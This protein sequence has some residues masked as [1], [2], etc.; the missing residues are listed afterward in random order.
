M[1]LHP[2]LLEAT[3]AEWAPQARIRPALTTLS[4][5]RPPPWA[6]RTLVRCLVR[7]AQNKR[8]RATVDGYGSPYHAQVTVPNTKSR[9]TWHYISAPRA[10]L[11][12]KSSTKTM[13][14]PVGRRFN[15][16]SWAS[17]RSRCSL[18]R[19]HPPARRESTRCLRSAIRKTSAS[20]V[21]PEW[22]QAFPIERP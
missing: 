19:F 5:H 20:A 4:R 3:L 17:R 12:P 22:R 14:R 2:E 7:C 1:A 6:R 13:A 10:I 18:S 11:A 16:S 21:R 8:W 9:W 15:C